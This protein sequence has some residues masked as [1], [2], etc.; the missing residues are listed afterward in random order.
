MGAKQTARTARR[1]D[2]HRGIGSLLAV[3]A[4]VP[5]VLTAQSP[6]P[7]LPTP[8]AVTLPWSARAAALGGTFVAGDDADVLFFNPGALPLARGM[9]IGVSRTD[10]ASLGASFAAVTTLGRWS[11]G[12]GIRALRLDELRL[13][14]LPALARS[15]ER[16]DP[17]FRAWRDA[18]I[19]GSAVASIGAAR[20]LGPIRLGAALHAGNDVGPRTTAGDP[21]GMRVL[22]DV[23]ATMPLW[24]GSLAA[25]A[26]SIGPD[27]GSAVDGR[28]VVDRQIP[29][30]YEIG[31]GIPLSPQGTWYDLGGQFA[32]GLDRDG[33]VASSG[34]V[35]FSLVPVE[36]VGL[37]ARVGSRRTQGV[38]RMT[39]G[40]SLAIDR[41]AFDVAYE[42]DPAAAGWR[43]GIRVR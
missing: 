14:A 5:A 22:A 27:P 38:A 35:E 8:V 2:A 4:L 16:S 18:G 32:V 7:V 42:P 28:A 19:A 26:R 40:T 37:V 10:D 29:T 43:L 17:A 15:G 31:Y 21:L 9:A 13:V 39:W 6:P 1:Q 24:F 23:G 36:G 30:R 11:L 34:G 33:N 20:R 25:V 3:W 12:A 41:M